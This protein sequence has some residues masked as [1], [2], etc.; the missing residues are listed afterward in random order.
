[1][2]PDVGTL[3]PNQDQDVFKKGRTTQVTCGHYVGLRRSDIKSWKSQPDGTYKEVVG[4]DSRVLGM[5]HRLDNMFGL[6]GDSGA[7]VI[8][9]SGE[10]L[11]LYWGGNTASG[12]GYFTGADPLFQDIKRI[13]GA[14]SVEMTG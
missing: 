10:F 3:R 9:R 2:I 12:A 4:E 7:F 8:D 13:T 5:P 1:V 11:G 6:W 14:T